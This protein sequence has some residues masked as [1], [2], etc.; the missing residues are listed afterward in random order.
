MKLQISNKGY[1]SGCHELG[2]AIELDINLL[3]VNS[4]I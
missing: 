1:P 2:N 3:N 4:E